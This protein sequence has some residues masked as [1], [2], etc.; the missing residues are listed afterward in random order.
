M[1]K[2]PT[3]IACSPMLAMVLLLGVVFC[4][5]AHGQRKKKE[6]P[7]PIVVKV[8]AAVPSLA[9]LAETQQSQAKSGLRIT[10]QPATYQTRESVM[11]AVQRVAPRSFLGMTVR[12]SDPRAVYVE[13]TQVPGLT[14][15]PDHIVFSV[16]LSNQMPRVFRGSG[17]VVQ[18]NV[19]GKVVPV[20]ASGYGDL[21]N[22]ILPPRSEQTITIIGPAITSIPT[23]CTVGVFF[24][25]VVTNIDQAGNVTEKQNFEWYFSYQTQ[26]VEKDVTIQP[27]ERLWIIP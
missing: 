3:V 9:A 15:D 2:N 19:A 21:I 14:V 12:P 26:R 25:D 16:H 20:E 7:Q 8:S 4:A 27:P 11:P 18:F 6:P 1:S 17:I 13:R 22:L 24:Y 10:M 23:P 5:A